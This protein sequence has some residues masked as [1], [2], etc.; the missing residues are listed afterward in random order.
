MIDLDQAKP[1]RAILNH[2]SDCRGSRVGCNY[3]VS[4]ATRLP[5]QVHLKATRDPAL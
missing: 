3:F 4:Q 1:M 2:F 5:L